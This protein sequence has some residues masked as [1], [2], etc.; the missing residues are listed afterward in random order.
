MS[1]SIQVNSFD[2]SYKPEELWTHRHSTKEKHFLKAV[3]TK[4]EFSPVVLVFFLNNAVDV[5]RSCTLSDFLG[6]APDGLSFFF[7]F[8]NFFYL[9]GHLNWRTAPPICYHVDPVMEIA[10]SFSRLSGVVVGD[11][12]YINA[13]SLKEQAD[14]CISHKQSQTGLVKKKRSG[15][16]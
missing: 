8:L 6:C 13:I 14:W 5:N 12:F 2:W 1:A 15:A 9:V 10:L 11:V 4:M 7:F 16:V 3:E